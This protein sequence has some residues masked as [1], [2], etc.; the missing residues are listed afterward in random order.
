MCEWVISQVCPRFSSRLD[1]SGLKVA[2]GEEAVDCADS[3]NDEV[4][5]A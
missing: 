1:F 5:T 4:V 3:G 2:A